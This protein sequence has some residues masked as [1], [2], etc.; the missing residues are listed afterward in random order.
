MNKYLS[1]CAKIINKFATTFGD[2]HQK[3]EVEELQSEAW[4]C[5]VEAYNTWKSDGGSKYTTYLFTRLA[6]LRKTILNK[7][8]RQGIAES[9]FSLNYPVVYQDY[10]IFEL[11]EKLKT[12]LT[13]KELKIFNS[14]ISPPSDFLIKSKLNDSHYAEFLGVSP[15]RLSRTLNKTKKLLQ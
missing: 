14:Y 13:T 4:L 2:Q 8:I 1:D 15:M 9:N 6:W 5:A 12:N 3:L 7:T 11:I 10:H